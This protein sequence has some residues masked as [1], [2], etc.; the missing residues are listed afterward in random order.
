[1]VNVLNF[2]E[3]GH[4]TPYDI[5][6]TNLET[7]H[8]TFAFNPHRERLFEN[9]LAFIDDL[10][11]LELGA[12]FQWIDGSFA[13]N[14]S[15]PNDIDCITFVNDDVIK[16][17]KSRLDALIERYRYRQIDSK[18]FAFL[19]HDHR[20]YNTFKWTLDECF[21]LYG[22]NRQSIEKGFIQLNF[23]SK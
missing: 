6:E 9:Y 17:K 18:Y 7:L 15:L 12:F 14:K 23:N 22:T 3:N 10:K 21:E 2:D 4:L 5:I 16:L 1:M 20:F 19:P 11:R 13:T 8:S